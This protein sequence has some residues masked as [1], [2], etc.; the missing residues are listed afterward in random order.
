MVAARPARTA[1]AAV[2]QAVDWR[3]S[4]PLS[5]LRRRAELAITVR[6]F[7]TARGVLE[8]ETPL[9]AAATATDLHLA[10]VRCRLEAPGAPGALWLQTSPEL[11]MKR[12]LAAGSGAIFQLARA[13]RGGE[14]GPLHNPELTLLEWYRPGFDHHALMDEVEELL[15]ATLGTGRAQ[16]LSYG[17]LFADHLGVDAHHADSE[18]LAAVAG[19]QGLEVAGAP[20][21]DRDTWLQLLMSGRIEPLLGRGRPTF[22]YDYPASQA[23]LARLRAGEPPVAER[24]EVYVEGVELANGFHELADAAEQEGRFLA[25]LAERRRRGLPEVPLDRRLLAALEHGLPDC[26]GVALGFDRL[27]MLATGASAIE[28]VLAFPVARA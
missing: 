13:V 19:R 12:L 16:R 9:L 20:V 11:H 26:A 27:A 28:E 25:D 22:V 18:Q 21:E 5:H 23:A 17:Q 4:A 10:S 2:A 24:F 6:A 14:A 7:F 8:V 15:A 1:G 3:P